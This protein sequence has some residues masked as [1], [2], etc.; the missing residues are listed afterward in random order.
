MHRRINDLQREEWMGGEGRGDSV[1]RRMQEGEMNMQ[2][3]YEVST[4]RQNIKLQI[5]S[6]KSKTRTNTNTN[7][8]ARILICIYFPSLVGVLLKLQYPRVGTTE[9]DTLRRTTL[10]DVWQWL[11]GLGRNQLPSQTAR[12]RE[13]RPLLPK[14]EMI[15]C[16]TIDFCSHQL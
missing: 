13:H 8:L 9:A 16:I 6:R 1:N 3:Q 15:S 2:S 12:D 7:T 10:R 14:P 4:P 11:G 5:I